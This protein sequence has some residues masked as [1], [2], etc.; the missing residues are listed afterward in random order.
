MWL[1]YIDVKFFYD[2]KRDL[3][4]LLR[5]QNEFFLLKVNMHEN[6]PALLGS[7]III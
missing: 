2:D 1:P 6:L 4:F 3:Q 7:L 5:I